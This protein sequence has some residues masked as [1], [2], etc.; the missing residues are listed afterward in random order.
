MRSSANDIRQ[1][2]YLEN[3]FGFVWIRILWIPQKL[4]SISTILLRVVVA[5]L[6][7]EHKSLFERYDAYAM[8][9]WTETDRHNHSTRIA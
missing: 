8:Q 6:V 1:I 3:L 9:S 4:Q 5:G 7:L 2:I